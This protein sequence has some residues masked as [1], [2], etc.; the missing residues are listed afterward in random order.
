MK[1]LSWPVGEV[2]IIAE[3]IGIDAYSS[4]NR[5]PLPHSA[6]LNRL[7]RRG[8]APPAARCAAAWPGGLPERR[9]TR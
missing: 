3:Q 7:A 8:F 1:D 4:R 2:P 5:L 6:C 9:N